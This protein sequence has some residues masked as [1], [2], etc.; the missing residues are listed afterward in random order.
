MTINYRESYGIFGASGILFNHESPL[1]GK[2]FVTRKI[3]KG[4]ARIKNA[5]EKREPFEPIELG[6]LDS[7][8]DWSDAEDF[9]DG[10]WRMLNQE[11]YWDFECPT[12]K[13]PKHLKE[14]VLSSNETH[15]IKEFV[16]LAFDAAGIKGVWK[17]SDLEAQYL[18]PNDIAEYCDLK[19]MQLVK[20]NPKFYRPAEVDLLWGD[21]AKAR[22]DLGWYPKT[23]F[24]SLIK[25]MVD[26]DLNT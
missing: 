2:E 26:N 23:D 3:S 12:E 11:L 6:N 19:S 1:R 10:V 15:S 18:I 25:K 5:I 9:V 7:K 21:S 17:G 13:I 14:Y 16:E 4:V 8:R 24:K 20:I 22:K